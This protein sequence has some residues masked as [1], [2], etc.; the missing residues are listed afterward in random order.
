VIV[1]SYN[2]DE[3]ATRMDKFVTMLKDRSP[4][5][6]KSTLLVFKE[7]AIQRPK[8]IAEYIGNIYIVATN[9]DSSLVANEA[10]ALIKY[11]DNNTKVNQYIE[12]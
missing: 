6:R 4:E 11:I 9:D 3:I 8:I 10:N 12:K 1:A 2:P 7:M 5:V